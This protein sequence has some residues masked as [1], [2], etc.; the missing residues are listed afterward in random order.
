[1]GLEVDPELEAEA[2]TLYGQGM[3]LFLEGQLRP[4]YEK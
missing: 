3:A 1:M 4:S 2:Q